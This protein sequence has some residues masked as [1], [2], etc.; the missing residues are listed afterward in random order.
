MTTRRSRF[1]PERR[2]PASGS[3]TPVLAWLAAGLCVIVSSLVPLGATSQVR[4]A[5]AGV[6]PRVPVAPVA[7]PDPGEV[8]TPGIDV[9]DP[10]VIEVAGVYFMFASQEKFFGANVPLW[11]STSLTSWGPTTLDAMPKLPSWAAPGF[12]WAP[13]VRRLDGRYVMWFNAALAT[14][15]FGQTKCIGVAT[16]SSVIGPYESTATAP[17][18]CQL[19]HLGSIDP[20]TFMDPE[21]RLWLLWKSDD[22]A[23]LTASTRTTIYVQQLS[24]DGLHLLGSPLALM[25]A[26]RPWE[27]RIVESP[28][29]VFAG[30]RYWLFFSGNWF[31]QPA[32]AIG[33]AQCAGPRGPCRPSSSGPWMASNAQGPGPG[34][35]SLFYDGSRWWM[36]YAP[37]AVNYQASTPRPA[38]LARLSFGP[39]GP[40]VVAPGTAAWDAPAPPA[41]KHE[42]ACTNPFQAPCPARGPGPMMK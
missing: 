34:E 16:A 22:N 1:G 7:L 39:N 10:F 41:T 29:M 21:G 6:L 20:H 5:T 3:R 23:R 13:D 2:R 18:V 19:G 36:L 17:L 33:V 12:T 35:E 9:P 32:Y 14:R 31:N 28:D 25:T 40:A 27:G 8:I 4:A 38:A 24:V 26:D 37:F 11:V 42:A 15:G 30:G